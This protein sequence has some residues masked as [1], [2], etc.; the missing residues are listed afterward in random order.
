MTAEVPRPWLRRLA[1]RFDATCWPAV[2]LR[3]VPAATGEANGEVVHTPDHYLGAAWAPPA[4]M[5]SRWPEVVVIGAPHADN[6]LA[7]LFVQ[8]P[9]DARLYLGDPD[10]VDALLAATILLATDR[11][12]EAYQRAGIERFIAAERARQDAVIAARFTDHDPGFAR[13]RHVVLAGSAADA[14]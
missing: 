5:L 13:F 11:H 4:T 7:E 12:L 9:P 14:S 3:V 2:V 8:L 1:A 6:A 10:Q